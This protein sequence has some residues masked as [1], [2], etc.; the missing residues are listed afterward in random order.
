VVS[1]R[2]GDLTNNRHWNYFSSLAN[3]GGGKLDCLFDIKEAA[4]DCIST[5]AAYS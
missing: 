5:A 1:L 4:L 3:C 2:L